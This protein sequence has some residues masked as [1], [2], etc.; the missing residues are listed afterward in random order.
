VAP[1]AAPIICWNNCPL[2][3]NILF[4]KTDLRR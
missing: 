2:N 3:S 1:I 4:S